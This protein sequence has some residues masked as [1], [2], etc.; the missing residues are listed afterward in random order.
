MA[1]DTK[2]TERDADARSASEFAE[3]LAKMTQKIHV[4][5]MID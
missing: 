1:V 2:T 4:H 5:Q 3:T